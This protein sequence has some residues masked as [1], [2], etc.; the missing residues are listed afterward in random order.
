MTDKITV[1]KGPLGEYIHL[2]IPEI[3][4]EPNK[5]MGDISHNYS[6]LDWII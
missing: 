5:V 2:N 4:G 6:E 1:S 3:I